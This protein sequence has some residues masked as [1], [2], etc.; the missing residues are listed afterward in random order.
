MVANPDIFGQTVFIRRRDDFSIVDGG[1]GD[2]ARCD[3]VFTVQVG[4]KIVNTTH[5]PVLGVLTATQG[6]QNDQG[7]HAVASVI[8]TSVA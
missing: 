6:Q 5:E 3:P 4:K 8:A 1:P 2:A 7:T